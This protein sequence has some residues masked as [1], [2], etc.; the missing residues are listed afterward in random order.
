MRVRSLGVLPAP[1]RIVFGPT[2]VAPRLSVSKSPPTSP[3]A[4]EIPLKDPILAAFLAWLIPGL[5]HLYQG[6]TAKGLLFL[7]CILGTFLYGL[8][9]G[10]GPE[11][12]WGRVVYASWRPSDERLPYFCQ[13]G[14]GLPS[15][16]ALVQAHR[17]RQ[18]KE[19]LF[20][21]FMAPPSL[22]PGNFDSHGQPSE[23]AGFDSHG[24]PT[25]HTL[26]KKLHRFFELGTVYTMIAGLLN[27]L[28]IFDAWG[29][30]V[31]QEE[32]AEEKAAL[33]ENGKGAA[34]SPQS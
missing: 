22:G 17:V 30:P 9:L 15:L 21:G 1:F 31:L 33:A 25:L 29:G 24:Q 7:V 4:S 27:L 32:E 13:L 2:Q 28:A 6:R 14:V 20:G 23:N 5:G 3:D 19:P 34:A 11:L 8:Y 16:P 26:N 18:G 12:G 10:S